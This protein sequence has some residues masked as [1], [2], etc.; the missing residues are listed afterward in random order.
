MA[1]ANWPLRFVRAI[2]AKF[3]PN[4]GRQFAIISGS[5][6]YRCE[7]SRAEL[8]RA[9]THKVT[10]ALASKTCLGRAPPSRFIDI[11]LGRTHLG[12]AG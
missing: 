2:V 9:A 3:W 1:A 12:R 6:L 5:T 10:I 4:G 11:I 7:P 8:S